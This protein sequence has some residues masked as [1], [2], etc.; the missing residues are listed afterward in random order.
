ESVCAPGLTSSAERA[1]PFLEEQCH[2]VRSWRASLSFFQSCLQ[3]RLDFTLFTQL[4]KPSERH[5]GVISWGLRPACPF[6]FLQYADSGDCVLKASAPGTLAIV[7]IVTLLL[8]RQNIDG[9]HFLSDLAAELDA[10]VADEHGRPG[11]EITNLVLLLAA[12]RAIERKSFALC[13]F[14]AHFFRSM[15]AATTTIRIA[16]GSNRRSHSRSATRSGLTSMPIQ[17]ASSLRLCC[18]SRLRRWQQAQSGTAQRS[19]GFLPI[20]E[21]LPNAALA[22]LTCA[23]SL[24]SMP[25]DRHGR[26]RISAR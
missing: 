22:Y 12:K 9:Q 21:A 2:R 15:I 5:P 7:P 20:P 16:R 4:T 6:L 18:A 25:Q 19:S 3:I 11:N 14:D 1:L 26:S 24:G 8:E 23:A 17:K 10:F 13:R